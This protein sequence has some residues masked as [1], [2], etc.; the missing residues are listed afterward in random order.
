MDYCIIQPWQ[1]TEGNVSCRKYMGKAMDIL[2]CGIDPDTEYKFM[3]KWNSYI[4]F[5]ATDSIP[6]SMPNIVVVDD[7]EIR[8]KAKAD[9]VKEVDTWDENGNI[10]RKFS[11]LRD[12]VKRIPTNLFDG[13]ALSRLEKRKNGAKN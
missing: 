11:V 3:S 4:G 13:A 10:N 8:M 2:L 9:V 5:A 7:K 12:K 1:D 6:V